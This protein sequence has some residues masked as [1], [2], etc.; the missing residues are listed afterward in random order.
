MPEV[1]ES[2]DHHNVVSELPINHSNLADA[3]EMPVPAPPIVS[4]NLSSLLS[5]A[6]TTTNAPSYL[7]TNSTSAAASVPEA[8]PTLATEKPSAPVSSME[9]EAAPS[10]PPKSHMDE[11]PA[12]VAGG[13]ATADPMQPTLEQ[14]WSVR[15]PASTH[16]SQGPYEHAQGLVSSGAAA[17]SIPSAGATRSA[18]QDSADAPEAAGLNPAEGVTGVEKAGQ[19]ANKPFM[20]GAAGASTAPEAGANATNVHKDAVSR[21]E[22][23]GKNPV[24][25]VESAGKDAVSGA[26][27]TGKNPVSGVE[28]AGKDAVSGA[29]NTG[30]N[31][32]DK[33]AEAP[34]EAAN[35]VTEAGQKTT[36]A[37]K[38]AAEEAAQ[39][40]K[41][42]GLVGKL[43]KALK[44]GKNAK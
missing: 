30:K 16:M 17:D 23:T 36:D 28:S 12:D 40:P 24:S 5:S 26:E 4:G 15:G 25:G 3:G 29:E 37:G 7:Q 1:L 8:T 41:K 35:K 43:K 14:A 2:A 27:N 39:K 33:V 19:G 20:D 22:N 44:I 32:F 31:A 6:N 11:W 10:A 21:A 13:T 34:K 42:L 18:V 9:P 38:K